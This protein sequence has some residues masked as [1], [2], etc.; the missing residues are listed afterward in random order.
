MVACLSMKY[1]N[2]AG[3]PVGVGA[4]QVCFICKDDYIRMCSWIYGVLVSMDIICCVVDPKN[5]V[6][7]DTIVGYVEIA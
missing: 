4:V 6:V 2:N 7:I 1:S 3:I 5:F